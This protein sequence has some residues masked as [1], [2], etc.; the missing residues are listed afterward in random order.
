M[1]VCALCVY[2][3][4]TYTN[5][6]VYLDC[7]EP[8]FNNTPVLKGR[9]AFDCKLTSDTEFNKFQKGQD[10]WEFWIW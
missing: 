5:V 6:H 7:V 1:A 2:V 9:R 3:L 4:F 10:Y 8:V